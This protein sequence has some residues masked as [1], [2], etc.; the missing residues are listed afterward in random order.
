MIEWDD[1]IRELVERAT[2]EQQRVWQDY[3]GRQE[4]TSRRHHEWILQL[5]E[6]A[7]EINQH[8]PAVHWM[9]LDLFWIRLVGVL[10]ELGGGYARL[11]HLAAL[12]GAAL[13][14]GAERRIEGTLRWWLHTF[15]SCI[16]GILRPLSEQEVIVV[17]WLRQRSA[18]MFQ[19][20]YGRQYQKDKDKAKAKEQRGVELLGGK[21]FTI[22]ET[23]AA[24]EN[25]LRQHGGDDV[26]MQVALVRKM[27]PA[28]RT[29]VLAYELQ[30]SLAADPG[31]GGEVPRS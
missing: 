14:D 27:S 30:V 5:R 19:R 23:D 15:H 11:I 26:S 20:G 2:P 4:A 22:D 31:L 12:D 8:G 29:F 7:E 28:I 3:K 1:R 21:L 24:R 9:A 16:S 17:D 10:H 6:L 13:D 18:H 25:V